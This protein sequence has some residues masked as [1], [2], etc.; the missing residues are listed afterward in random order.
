[1]SGVPVYS[2]RGRGGGWELIGGARTD[3]TGLSE[4]E[5]QALMVAANV[6]G[7]GGGMLGP[8]LS[9]A[10]RKLVQAMPET[11]RGG[12][13]VASRAVH[14]DP[15]R[16]SGPGVGAD[17]YFLEPLQEAVLGGRQIELGYQAP[18][19][20]ASM[21]RVHPWG[22]VTKAS[23]WYLVAGTERGRRTF[24]VSRVQSVELTGDKV[25]RPDDFDL[26]NAWDAIKADFGVYVSADAVETTAVVQPWMMSPLRN[27]QSSRVE[28]L[29][30][31]DDGRLLVRVSS[32]SLDVLAYGF[33]GLGPDV[34]LDGP[35]E[36]IARLG[37]IGEDLAT[38]Y[39]S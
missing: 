21:R 7:A 4:R 33:A 28:E 14:V 11:F 25:E 20:E 2:N 38:R 1:M 30:R 16:W 10:L 27:L 19:R 6:G 29:V 17:P 22:L 37:A 36:L 34:E 5:A 31:R 8:E 26:G 15:N 18:G 32:S 39:S 23:I 24:R 13:E 3:L 9:G 12:A 35:P